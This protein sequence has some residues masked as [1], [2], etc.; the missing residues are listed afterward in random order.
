MP[1][2]A[3][4]R[5]GSPFADHRVSAA[6]ARFFLTSC[7]RSHV[8]VSRFCESTPP[9]TVSGRR[10]FSAIFF[11]RESGTPAMRASSYSLSG[12]LAPCRHITN[13]MRQ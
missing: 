13:R 7:T 6:S 2:G 5:G 12:N 1:G 10:T 11:Q 3:R 9:A 4:L 8:S